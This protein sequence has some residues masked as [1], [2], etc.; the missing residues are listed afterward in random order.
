V[1]SADRSGTQPVTARHRVGHRRRQLLSA[2]CAVVCLLLVVAQPARAETVAPS[3]PAAPAAPAAP[4]DAAGGGED[5]QG[6]DA[7]VEVPGV[8]AVPDV[9]VSVDSEDGGLSRTV[10]LL[11]LL[12]VG[13]V[14]PALLLLTT[15]FTR[16]VVVLGLAKNAIGAQTVPP[17]QVIVGLSLFLTFFVMGPTFST[18][19]EEAV[20]PMLAGELSQ[21]DAL[22]AGVAPLRE[23]MLA[24]TR[25][26]DL[27]LFVSLSDAPE[28]ASPD[29]VA[30]TTLIPAFVISELRAAFVIGFVVFVPFLVIDLVVASILMSLGMMMLPPVF[31]SLPIKIL[32]FILVDGWALIVGSLVNSVQP[33]A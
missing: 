15:T 24:Q 18:I 14:A 5:A 7:A 12:T 20:Q 22:E 10:V 32:L 1:S 23:F 21:G 13:S 29:D 4:D 9:V 31:V 27:A 19:N 11:L 33:I 16:F 26:D 2:L 30:T 8:P 28:P 6:D 3:T 17:P 25:E